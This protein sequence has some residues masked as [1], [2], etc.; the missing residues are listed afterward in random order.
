MK[1]KPR[2]VVPITIF[3]FAALAFS[4]EGTVNIVIGSILLVAA[5]LLT[6]AV[7]DIGLHWRNDE[8]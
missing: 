5:V 1:F 3:I 6:L 2:F 7:F 4:R 8:Q